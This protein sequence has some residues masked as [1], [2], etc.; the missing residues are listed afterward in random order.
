MIEIKIKDK[1]YKVKLAI[2]DEEKEQGLQGVTWLPS[3]EGMLFV[4]DDVEPSVG[5]WM[6]DTPLNLDLIFIG[7]DDKVISVQQG[8]ANT[9]DAHEEFDVQYVL[10]LNMDS[11]VEAGDLVETVEDDSDDDIEDDPS[12][13]EGEIEED[14]VEDVPEE[15]IKMMI[16]NAKGK[17]Q[18][19]LEGGERIFSRKNTIS[20]LKFAKRAYESKSTA[21]YKTL[22][23]KAFAFMDT[24]DARGNDYVELP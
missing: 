15:N 16:L 18:M 13:D 12:K 6:E 7:A 2:T 22:G 9:Q 24:Q 8:L 14:A 1:I 21:S 17:S 5:Y 23:K 19:D 4:Y 10:E 3:D 20:L 11:G